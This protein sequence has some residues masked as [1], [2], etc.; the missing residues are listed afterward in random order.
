MTDFGKRRVHNKAVYAKDP[1]IVIAE[2]RLKAFMRMYKLNS[3][4]VATFRPLYLKCKERGC[5]FKALGK[6]KIFAY[7]ESR[8]TCAYVGRVESETD[9]GIYF[10]KNLP[11][12]HRDERSYRV[13]FWKV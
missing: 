2:S 10:A 1:D 13:R 7:D 6:S 3:T 9:L 11:C 5:I 12:V 8:G 4:K